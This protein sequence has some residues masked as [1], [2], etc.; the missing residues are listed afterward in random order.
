MSLNFNPLADPT[1]LRVQKAIESYGPNEGNDIL[2]RI[3]W[4]DPR[5]FFE[6]LGMPMPSSYPTPEQVRNEALEAYSQIGPS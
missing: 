5:S 3:N 2:E 6:V 4:D 1:G